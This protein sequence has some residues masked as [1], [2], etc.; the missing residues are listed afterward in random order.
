MTSIQ[1]SDPDG[2]P[3]VIWLE[4]GTI[5]GPI[6]NKG[7]QQT[8]STV[9]YPRCH[10]DECSD[11]DRVLGF[12]RHKNGFKNDDDPIHGDSCHDLERVYLEN[13]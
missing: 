6:L 9:F 11:H 4:E 7:E 5:F 12:E 10:H 3:E 2:E 1:L 13:C 8:N